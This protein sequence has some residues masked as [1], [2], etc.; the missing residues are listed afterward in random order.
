MVLLPT[1]K[2]S[3]A[4]FASSTVN[5]RWLMVLMK[6]SMSSSPLASACTSDK[7][8]KVVLH[9]TLAESH[10]LQYQ[11]AKHVWCI[12]DILY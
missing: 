3:F 6:A 1:M 5:L 7:A 2:T 9:V 4:C 12:L 11:S 8:E 10:L